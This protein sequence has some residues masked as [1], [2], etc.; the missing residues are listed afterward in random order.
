MNK[1]DFYSFFY[2]DIYNTNSDNPNI[3][4]DIAYL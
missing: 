3:V 2:R 1:K 4:G